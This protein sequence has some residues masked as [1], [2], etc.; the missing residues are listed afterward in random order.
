MQRNRLFNL[1]C[2]PEDINQDKQVDENDLASYMNYTGL[3]RGDSEFEGYISKG[4]L[5]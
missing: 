2:I 3:H 5:E 4:G 1:Y